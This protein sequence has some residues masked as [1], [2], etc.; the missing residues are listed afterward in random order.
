VGV[1]FV[2]LASSVLI[3]WSQ[4]DLAQTEQEAAEALEHATARE[5]E[6]AERYAEA[7]EAL[8][9][10]EARL[11]AARQEVDRA[12]AFLESAAEEEQSAAEGRDQAALRFERSQV[13]IARAEDRIDTIAASA[14]QHSGIYTF[15]AVLSATGPQ[16]VIA[17]LGLV[18]RVAATERHALAEWTAAQARAGV[19]RDEADHARQRAE[20]ARLAAQEALDAARAAR[21]A[22]EEAANEVTG[23]IEAR[24]GALAVAEE[25]R[26]KAEAELA[27]VEEELR[28]REAANRDTAPV[29]A[30][31]TTLRMPVDATLTSGYGI[32]ID[33]I[34][35]AERLH[36]G[37]D[38]AAPGGAPIWAAADGTVIQAGWI[39]GYGNFTCVSHGTYEGQ[40]LSTCYAHQ[41]EILVSDGR[42]VQAGETIG[43]VGS[44]GNSTGNHLHFEV[45]LDGSPTDPLPWLPDCLC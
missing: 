12:E 7:T 14:Y 9:E 17:R 38:F 24:A 20:R 35:G 10:A 37:V 43:R 36:A 3:A 41:S 1:L 39:T 23:L 27:R 30:S 21:R 34:T 11:A 16:D 32:R 28:A 4:E 18:D 8:P 5:R 13:E 44:T 26:E 40:G 25:E 6:A 31:G 15:S 45:R 29:L 2:T 22:A 19:A 42:A 33:P